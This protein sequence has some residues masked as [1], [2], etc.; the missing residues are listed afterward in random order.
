MEELDLKGGG[1]DEGYRL[2]DDCIRDNI[3]FALPLGICQT[4]EA[5]LL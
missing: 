1:T 5:L 3:S 2:A 4:P